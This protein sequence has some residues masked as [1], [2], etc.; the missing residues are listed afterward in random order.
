MKNRLKELR[1]GQGLTQEDLGNKLGV[2]RYAIMALESDRHDPSLDLA[3]RISAV[4][5]MPIEQIFENPYWS[6]E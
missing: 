6:L 4:F 1:I 2:S 3:C 5:R